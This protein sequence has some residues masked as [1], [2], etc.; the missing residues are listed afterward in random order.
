V[1]YARVCVREGAGKKSYVQQHVRT[2]GGRAREGGQPMEE[3]Q[4]EEKDA[5][6]E[7]EEVEEA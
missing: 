4:A 1:C 2:I 6:K 3:E 5:G 7:E